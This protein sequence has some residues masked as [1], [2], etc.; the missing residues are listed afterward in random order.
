[1]EEEREEEDVVEE[2]EQLCQ[3]VGD[4]SVGHQTAN[5]RWGRS[6]GE[7]HQLG[8]LV[9]VSR[10]GVRS[11]GEQEWE[12]IEMAVDSRATETVIG[13]DMLRNIENKEGAAFKRVC[14]VRGREW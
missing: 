1:M 6:A 8:T 2:P 13:E 7:T 9:E 11:V 10:E 3:S 14:P 12:E 4:N 5:R